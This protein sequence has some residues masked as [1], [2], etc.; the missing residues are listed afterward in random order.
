MRIFC[1]GRNYADHAR[2]LGNA[3]PPPEGP[4]VVFMKPATSLIPPGNDVPWPRHGRELHHE[5]EVVLRIGRT[6]S[7][8]DEE[9]ALAFIDGI[10]LGF[11]LTLRD[12]QARL[13]AEGLP[14][15]MAKS[16]EG[17]ALC[18][19]FVDVPWQRIAFTGSVN[20]DVRQSGDTDDMIFS[21]PRLV[22]ELG[23]VWTLRPGDIVFTGTPAG[24][25]PLAPGD[26]LVAESPLLGRFAWRMVAA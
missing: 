24:V 16:F 23:K 25:G 4:P 6:G 19:A 7:P 20:G 12:V 18:G 2:E 15:E 21:A 1:I 5:T 9:E 17:S 11:D 13:K 26:G 22:V 3:P 8:A 14:W 10:S